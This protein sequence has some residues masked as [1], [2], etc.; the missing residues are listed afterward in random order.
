[1]TASIVEATAGYGSL[2]T[3]GGSERMSLLFARYWGREDIQT[4]AQEDVAIDAEDMLT[5]ADEAL[6]L[7]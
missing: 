6:V 7:G 2:V 5:Q 1:M 4:R 3:P